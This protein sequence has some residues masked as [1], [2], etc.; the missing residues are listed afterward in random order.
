MLLR[1][2]NPEQRHPSCSSATN[3]EIFLEALQCKAGKYWKKLIPAVPHHEKLFWIGDE[4]N[5]KNE[6]KKKPW[7][8]LNL[9]WSRMFMR[10][11]TFNTSAKRSHTKLGLKLKYKITILWVKAIL[12]KVN[13]YELEMS[14]DDQLSFSRIAYCGFKDF[15]DMSDEKSH[16]SHILKQVRIII[17]QVVIVNVKAWTEWMNMHTHMHTNKPS[18]SSCAHT[19]S[20]L[21]CSY[22]LPISNI[23]LTIESTE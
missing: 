12:E 4:S 23:R 15:S 17:Y 14:L 1:H 21:Q 22:T 18:Q 2:L 8:I 7:K 3:K 11:V 6:K 10:A 13:F 20:S 16:G 5:C 9:K 19:H